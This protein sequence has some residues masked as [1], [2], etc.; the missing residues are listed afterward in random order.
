MKNIENITNDD[1]KRVLNMSEQE[2]EKR[3]SAIDSKAIKNIAGNLSGADIKKQL[4]S[5]SP[6]D[7]S[8]L[9]NGLGKLNPSLLKKIKEAIK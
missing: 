4:S 7:I 5:K 6:D 8:R 2:I 3:L 9:I 1:I